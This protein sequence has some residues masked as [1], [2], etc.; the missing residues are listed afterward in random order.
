M[1]LLRPNDK[2]RQALDK[3]RRDR[4]QLLSEIDA[5]A[6]VRL[7]LDETVQR[8]LARL[9]DDAA[10]AEQ[11]VVAFSR[12]E[13]SPDLPAINAALL[14]WL[15]PKAFEMQLRARLK[16]LL[17]VSAPTLASRPAAIAK[18]K[19]KLIEL[20]HQEERAVGALESQGLMVDR[21]SDV[22]ID[23]LLK[24]WDEADAVSDAR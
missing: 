12:P 8:L 18:L 24:I 3:I 6:D 23:V 11:S 15:D 16:P 10:R 2:R 22:D 17:P 14:L 7:S 4:E 19:A 1:E 20:D 13:V 5:T 9:R 21:R